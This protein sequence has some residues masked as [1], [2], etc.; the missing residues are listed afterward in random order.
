MTTVQKF[1]AD[2]RE[3]K[4]LPVVALLLVAIVAVPIALSKS[5]AP[6]PATTASPGPVTAPTASA[7]PAVSLQPATETPTKL[8]ARPHNPFV[9]GVT[10]KLHAAVTGATPG[11]AGVTTAATSAT[12]TS[13][14]A[15]GGGTSTTANSTTS[16]TSTQTITTSAV[17]ERAGTLLPTQSYTV[18]VALAKGRGIET[19]DPLERLSPLPGAR[20]PLLVELGVLQGG[21]RVLFAVH[22]GAVLVGGGKCTPGPA[23]CQ[24]LSLGLG[25]I[26]GVGYRTGAGTEPITE[27]AV[28]AIRTTDHA[29]AAA[30]TKARSRQS[31]V[32]A[33]V[34]KDIKLRAF[35]SFKYDPSLGVVVHRRNLRAAGRS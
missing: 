12:T 17:T 11:G 32:G 16:T 30:A 23:D 9:Q 31:Q 13:G 26:E 4:L 5:A 25:E 34:L 8:N 2:L 27:L 19:I 20:L 22:P 3:R 14:S 6:A 7:L 10:R 28:T 21:K 33:A 15:A 29:S 24:V 18:G 35:S 1:I